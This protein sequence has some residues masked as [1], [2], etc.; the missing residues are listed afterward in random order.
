MRPENVGFLKDLALRRAAVSRFL[1]DSM[2]TLIFQFERLKSTAEP[3]T[4]ADG[5]HILG[6]SSL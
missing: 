1:F 5:V 6:V 2:P 4:P 3:I